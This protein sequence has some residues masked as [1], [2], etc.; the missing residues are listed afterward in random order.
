MHE[1]ALIR[2]INQ[3]LKNTCKANEIPY[4]IKSHSFR[5]NVISSLLKI[6][7]VQNTAD[8]IGHEDIRSTMFYRRYALPKTEIQ[9]LLNQINK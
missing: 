2:L 5:I 1:K 8:I 3:D 9:D 7:S 4:N 6:T